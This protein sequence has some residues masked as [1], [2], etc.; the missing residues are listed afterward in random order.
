MGEELILY[1]RL[2]V[3]DLI[4]EELELFSVDWLG[5]EVS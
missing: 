2:G 1:G 4:S 5:E 3:E